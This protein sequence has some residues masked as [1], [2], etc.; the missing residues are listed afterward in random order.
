M[1]E[2]HTA[3]LEDI[4]RKNAI[5]LKAARDTVDRYRNAMISAY[6]DLRVAVIDF[7][8]ADKVLLMEVREVALLLERVSHE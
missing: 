3:H 5:E 1:S 7:P 6:H 4:V 8:T 2:T